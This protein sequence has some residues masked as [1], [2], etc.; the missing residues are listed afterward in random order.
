M[1]QWALE[2]GRGRSDLSR[3]YGNFAGLKWRPEMAGFATKIVYEAHDGTDLYCAFPSAQAFVR[4]YWR[5]IGRSVYDGWQAYADDPR[6]FLGFLKSR[7]YAGDPN[8]VEKVM[9]ILPEAEALLGTSETTPFADL[10]E[11]ERP[12]RAELGE[13]LFDHMAVDEEPDFVALPQV[14]HPFRGAR[15]NGLEGA[16]VH[17]DA[18]RTRPTRGADDLE[19]GARNTLAGAQSNGFAYLTISRTGKIYLP[20]NMDWTKW[21]YHAGKS[22]CP[23]TKREGVSRYY[24]GFEVN[25]PGLVHP[26]ADAQVYVPWF[27]AVRDSHGNVVLDAKGRATVANPKGELYKPGELRLVKQRQGN[28]RA[29]AY[30]P[31]TDKQFAALVSVMLWL[32]QLHP[33][34][35]R[36]DYVFGHD[37]VSPGRKV[38]PGGSLGEPDAAGPGAPMPMGRFRAVLLKAWAERQALVA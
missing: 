20:N 26:T 23:V 10:G 7:G 25:S 11:S 33:R 38:D 14:T 5:F 4:G 21:G 18:G 17:Y 19:W 13:T 1:A 36:L 28:I 34:T 12:S 16:I 6:G 22:L 15:P 27:D 29:G 35:F 31:Y 24:V 3:R 30:V 9:Q 8:Y 37:E 32:K 2:S